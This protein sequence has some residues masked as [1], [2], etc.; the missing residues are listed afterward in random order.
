MDPEIV[1]A[2]LRLHRDRG[3]DYTSN[4]LPRTFPKGLDVEVVDAQALRAAD[5]EAAMR[6]EREHVMPFL[7]RR[8][9]RFG[10][11]N[12]WCEENLGHERWTVDTPEDLAVVRNIVAALDGRVSFG[13][14]EA[15]AARPRAFASPGEVVLHPARAADSALLLEWRNDADTVRNSFVSE[16]VPPDVHT[17]WL[18][19]RLNDPATRIYVGYLD[20]TP[21]GMVRVD[22][23]DA[24]GQ[25]S[26]AVAPTMRGCGVGKALLSAF[27][28]ERRTDGQ[29]SRL[30]GRVRSTN[31][32]SLKIF[33]AAG[34]AVASRTPTETV[35][36]LD[37]FPR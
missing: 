16:P 37:T 23:D 19:G 29:F 8:P 32:G 12:L 7:Y 25:I 26:I 1:E 14:R 31:E 11:A 28:A 36:G 4:V 17:R 13:W 15:L 2:A 3:A 18:T 34:F 6:L 21:V 24:V 35:F 10:L 27:V 22:V 20:G 5:A 33:A 9:S 30:E